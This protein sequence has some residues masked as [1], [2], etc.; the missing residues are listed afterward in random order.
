MKALL[1]RAKGRPGRTAAAGYRDNG[2]R[3]AMRA[4][5]LARRSESWRINARFTASALEST[6][7][8][9]LIKP[10]PRNRSFGNRGSALTIVS[11]FCEYRFKTSLAGIILL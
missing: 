11:P 4:I 8:C 9:L 7:N 10:A 2:R 1:R 5:M 6:A 3:E